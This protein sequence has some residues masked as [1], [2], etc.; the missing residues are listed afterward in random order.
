M[1]MS[2]KERK[3]DHPRHQT[4]TTVERFPRTLI[5]HVMGKGLRI[6]PAEQ[7]VWQRAEFSPVDITRM[8]E[9]ALLAI[10]RDRIGVYIDIMA[11][12]KVK[13]Y[14]DTAHNLA[15]KFNSSTLRLTTHSDEETILAGGHRIM[16]V[17][18]DADE[19]RLVWWLSVNKRSIFGR[20]GNSGPDFH[21]EDFHHK[22]FLAFMDGL[23][24]FLTDKE[25]VDEF[26]KWTK[27][28]EVL[29]EEEVAAHTESIK[30]Y[31]ELFGHGVVAPVYNA[32]A[33]MFVK[34]G[35]QI[36]PDWRSY[37]AAKYTPVG[38]AI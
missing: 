16:T 13:Q 25:K 20:F 26:F 33:V 15:G 18:P 6:D 9:E 7:A 12:S 21:H 37:I 23:S 10:M 27:R 1:F 30:A 32:D 2:K 11:D 3:T 19:G 22:R 34:Q 14:R 5:D 8:S 29:V 24:P 17:Y 38:R 31:I 36:T 35:C 4:A 28:P